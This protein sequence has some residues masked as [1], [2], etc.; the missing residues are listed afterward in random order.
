MT[1]VDSET[2]ETIESENE[3]VHPGVRRRPRLNMNDMIS[4]SDFRNAEEVNH[5]HDKYQK[6]AAINKCLTQTYVTNE[7]AEEINGWNSR[8]KRIIQDWKNILEYHFIVNWVLSVSVETQRGVLVVA[9]YCNIDNNIHVITSS[10]NRR[11]SRLCG[12]RIIKHLLCNYYS[13]CFVG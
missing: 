4:L 2:L 12:R 9:H 1:S 6:K 5:V 7:K 8:K 13:H 11:G 3:Q 10:P